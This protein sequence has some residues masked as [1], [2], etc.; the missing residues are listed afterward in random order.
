MK[1]SLDRKAK[2]RTRVAFLF[3]FVCLVA[4][5]AGAYF[6]TNLGPLRQSTAAHESQTAS[7]GIPDPVPIDE[8]LRRRPSSKILQM[9]AMATK[10]ADETSVAAEQLF[11]DIEPPALAKQ[12]NLGTAS[13]GDL[14]ALRGDLKTAEA[15]AS[16]AMPR[17][18][19]L[20]KTER[21]RI[22]TYV[23]F[24][25][26]GK[27]VAGRFL[28]EVDKRHA[29]TIDVI[30]RLLSARADYYRAY[31]RYVAVLAGE[32]GAYKVVDGQFIFPLQPTVDR[33][34]AAA[35]AMTAAAKRV[36]ELEA[37]RTQLMASQQQQWAQFA[38]SQ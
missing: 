27:D 38:N 10:A 11:N 25:H 4:L 17:C 2:T 18:S 22:E 35:Q 30:A 31:G 6:I 16:T 19:A 24:L 29:K 23:L 34:N 32:F 7:P 1:A 13:R 20:I 5:S 9:I 26:A 21:D 14:E 28:N 33:Y 36:T 15:N 8:A 3:L 37:E 12:P